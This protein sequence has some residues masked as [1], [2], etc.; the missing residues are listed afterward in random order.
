MFGY[1]KAFE[2]LTWETER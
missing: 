1:R 2:I